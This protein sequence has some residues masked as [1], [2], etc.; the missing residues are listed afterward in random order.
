MAPIGARARS[1]VG[2]RARRAREYLPDGARV[3]GVSDPLE[4]PLTLAE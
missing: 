4:R 2:S 1:A 3:L